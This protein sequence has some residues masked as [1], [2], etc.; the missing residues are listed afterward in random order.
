[1]LDARLASGEALV[2]TYMTQTAIMEDVFEPQYEERIKVVYLLLDV[3]PSM[4]DEGWRV[5]IWKG[6]TL[7][8]VEKAFETHAPFLVR[9][10]ANGTRDM[11]RIISPAQAQTNK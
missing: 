8:L 7:R 10:F 3:S 2:R 5:P 1:M 9:E 4:W 6:V 11:K